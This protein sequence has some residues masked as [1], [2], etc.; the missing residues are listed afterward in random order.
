MYKIVFKLNSPIC[1]IDPPIF[2]GIL[3]YCY[4]KEKLGAVPQKLNLSKDEVMDFSPMPLKMHEDGYF[5]ASQMQY[6]CS[7][8]FTSSWKKRWDS[9][10]DSI[11]DFGKSKRKIAVNAGEFKSYD[12]PKN[13]YT[14]PTCWF[15]F[16]SDRVDQVE[17][18]IKEYCWGLGK[19]RSQGDGEIEELKIEAIE[20][21]FFENLLRPIPIRLIKKG[22]LKENY[23]I[24]YTSW[25]PPYWLMDNM[26][27]CG[28]PKTNKS[29]VK[30]ENM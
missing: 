3:A 23:K 11:A 27:I 20:M 14:I 30:N 1:F 10:H 12:M 28:V 8:N 24:K 7:I 26:E 22:G 9:K 18:L 25:K 13:M 16:D 19:K 17:Y 15:Y 29:G 5:I 4:I 2:D 6:D 21:D